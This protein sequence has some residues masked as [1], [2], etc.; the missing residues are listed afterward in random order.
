MMGIKDNRSRAVVGRNE[1]W[2]SL[3]PDYGALSFKRYLDCSQ[4][5]GTKSR[6]GRGVGVSERIACSNRDDSNIRPHPHANSLTSV[7]CHL[8]EVYEFDTRERQLK[9]AREESRL[10]AGLKEKNYG[11]IVVCSPAYSPMGGWMQHREGLNLLSGNHET[12]RHATLL[13]QVDQ[14]SIRGDHRISP[15]PKLPD[16]EV[17]Q[18][19]EQ[20]VQMVVVRMCQNDSVQPPD[21]P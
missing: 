13:C 14:R 9:I 17:V 15:E 18:G 10:M 19:V 8:Q 3:D 21:A 5:I 6:E 12:K 7:V 16:P 1:L 2:F 4:Q 11:V 20:S